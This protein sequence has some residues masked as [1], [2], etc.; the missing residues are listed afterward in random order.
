MFKTNAIHK[1]KNGLY[2]MKPTTN[3]RNHKNIQYEN[4]IDKSDTIFIVIY[5]TQFILYV[6]HTEKYIMKLLFT[7]ML[8]IIF[9]FL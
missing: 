6:G 3:N 2:G 7:R 9:K 5:Y 8:I 4:L 1:A